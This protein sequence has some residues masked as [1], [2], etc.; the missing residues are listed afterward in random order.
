[1]G[2]ND[3]MIKK[4]VAGFLFSENGEQVALI[5]KL[6]PEWQRDRFNA[7]GGKVE[8][9]ETE[10]EAMRR[11]F[12]EEAGLDVPDWK[13]FCVLNGNDASY[14]KGGGDFE[15]HFF[16]HFSDDVYKVKKMEIE[17][18]TCINVKMVLH[19]YGIGNIIPN[20]TWLIPLALQKGLVAKVHES[21]NT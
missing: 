14:V 9:G 8:E 1:M 11:E 3:K 13:L 12:E 20:L 10:L 2:G 16:S 18:I 19:V 17:D 7:I 5:K 4:Y 15:I 6:K 21:D